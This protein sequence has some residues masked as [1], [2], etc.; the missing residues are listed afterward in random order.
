M[1]MPQGTTT[2]CLLCGSDVQQHHPA[3]PGYRLGS[4]FE[5]HHCAACDT[6]FAHPMEV[7]SAI[8]D[9]IYAHPDEIS[10]YDRYAKYARSV[11]EV[12][13]P[14]ALLADSEDVYWSIR[15]C[16]EQLEPGARILEVG[17]GL[18]YM[19]YALLKAGYNVT[20]MDISKVAVEN[21]K[22]RYGP[23]YQEA[24]LAEWSVQ[25]AGEFDMVLMAELIEHIPDPLAFLR[26]AAKLLRPGGRLVVTTPNKSHYPKWML[27]ESDPPPV[28]LWW[29]SEA[30]M[31]VF[32]RELGLGIAFVDFTPFNRDHGAQPLA[33]IHMPGLPTQGAKL[34]E[35]NRPLA[36]EALL[37]AERARRPRLYPLRKFQRSAVRRFQSLREWI[38]PTPPGRSSASLCAVLTKPE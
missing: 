14:L 13:D 1:T 27:W 17:S 33:R 3:Q 7:D 23:H 30:S 15:A 4:T 10:G 24:D 34:D 21:A 35:Q 29:F 12:A 28:H 22:A 16:V 20:G 2:R 5:I 36:P 6:S 18:G 19:T 26:M 11:L 25:K 31:K 38:R 9:A 37:R 32:A 8:Y